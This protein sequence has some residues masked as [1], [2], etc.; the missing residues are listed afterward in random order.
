MSSSPDRFTRGL[1]RIARRAHSAARRRRWL[2]AVER[3]EDYVLLTTY[4]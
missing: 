1:K 3:L 2:P 4:K